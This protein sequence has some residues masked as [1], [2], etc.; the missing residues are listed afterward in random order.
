MPAPLKRCNA[1]RGGLTTFFDQTSLPG[2][3]AESAA[4]QAGPAPEVW[5]G[6][7][8]AFR[9]PFLSQGGV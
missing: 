7:R 1:G 6:R 3:R 9:R 8:S 2:A 5:R 4:P